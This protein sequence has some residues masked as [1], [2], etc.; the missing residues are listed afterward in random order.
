M[1]APAFGCSATLRGIFGK[2]LQY[3]LGEPVMTYAPSARHRIAGSALRRYREGLGYSL[4]DA[5][6]I[7][8][9]D[10]SKISRIETG[11]RGIRPKELRELLAEYGIDPDSREALMA[12][13]GPRIRDG[14]WAGFAH[15]LGGALTDFLAAESAATEILVYAPVQVPGLLQIAEYAQAVAAADPRVSAEAEDASVAAVL[16]RQQ[17]TL[18]ERGTPLTVVIGE[19]AL[20]QQV[21]GAAV[22]RAQLSCLSSLTADDPQVTIHVLPYAAGA[23]AAGGCG[24]FSILQFGQAPA[25]GMV[26][27]AGPS[28][29]TC[30]EDPD[31]AAAYLRAFTRLRT[32]ALDPQQSA[33]KMRQAS[34]A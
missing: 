34:L 31:A 7:L 24:E 27:L 20:R 18:R 21:G 8:E 4:A 17:V 2:I 22:L 16:I 11:H 33:R 9:C 19:A 3:S 6:R 23:H 15:V 30:P 14:W 1:S 5:A 10:P 12:I 26:N 32:L 29:G 25:L 13:A 28:G